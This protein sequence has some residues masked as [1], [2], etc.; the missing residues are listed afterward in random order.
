MKHGATNGTPGEKDLSHYR[1][2]PVGV[3][4]DVNIYS[5]ARDIGNE[6][7]GYKA[8]R[9]G[10]GYQASRNAFDALEVFQ[11]KRFQRESISSQNAEKDGW[12]KG[13]QTT[14]ARLSN[15]VLRIV[16]PFLAY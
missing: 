3:E 9:A 7:A 6:V 10:F 13:S 8:G 2:M 12:I 11:K 1:G 16:F 4:D 14:K 15:V 5:S